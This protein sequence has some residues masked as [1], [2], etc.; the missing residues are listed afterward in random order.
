MVKRILLLGRVKVNGLLM[1][2]RYAVEG[3]DK[4]NLPVILVHGLSVSS[5]Y[6]VPIAEELASDSPV[7][8]PDMPG[9]GRSEKPGN[10]LNISELADALVAWM[11]ACGL[12]RAVMLGNSMGCQIIIEC[13]LR[14]SERV[15]AMVLVGPTTEPGRRNFFRQTIRLLATGLL[16]PPGILPVVLSDYLKAGLRRT[17][18]TIR[19]DPAQPNSEEIWPSWIF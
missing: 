8:A 19:I 11:D 12:D 2:Y 15:S 14:Y 16:E 7:Y 4:D 13:A 17:I 18:K 6:L 10:V 5:R 9:F 3:T 1:F